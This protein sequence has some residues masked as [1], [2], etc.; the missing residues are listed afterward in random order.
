[1]ALERQNS[2]PTQL[3]RLCALKQC[4]QEQFFW[5]FTAKNTGAGNVVFV[6][7]GQKSGA[8]AIGWDVSVEK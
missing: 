7:A 1:M 4:R 3:N 5:P 2:I 8:R 6:E